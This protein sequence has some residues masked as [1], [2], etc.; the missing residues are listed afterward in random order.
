M[1]KSVHSY[2]I[3]HPINGN[4]AIIVKNVMHNLL[5]KFSTVQ[6]SM[7]NIAVKDSIRL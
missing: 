6:E 5:T 7:Y 2:C 4:F 1:S 3:W